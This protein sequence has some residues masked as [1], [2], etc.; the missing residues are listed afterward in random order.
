MPQ[1]LD[2]RCE[3]I[4][5]LIEFLGLSFHEIEL[6]NM[7]QG[8]E[9]HLLGTSRYGLILFLCILVISTDSESICLFDHALI[10]RLLGLCCLPDEVDLLVVNLKA[11]LIVP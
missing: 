1:L 2:F 4:N 10:H 8:D 9:L 7:N 5:H 11:L 3:L 6:G